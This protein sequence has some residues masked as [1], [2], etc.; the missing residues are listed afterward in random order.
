MQW[1]ASPSMAENSEL[2][3]EEKGDRRDD[4]FQGKAPPRQYRVMV[5]DLNS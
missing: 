1:V 3:K 4:N 2:T 5:H